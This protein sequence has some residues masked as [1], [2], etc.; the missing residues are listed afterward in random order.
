MIFKEEN[1]QHLNAAKLYGSEE[2]PSYI[3][4]LTYKFMQQCD[5]EKKEG[6][7]LLASQLLYVR[8]ILRSIIADPQY[9]SSK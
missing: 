4:Q 8:F 9:G 3:L 5:Q 2:K 1:D 6:S 7:K